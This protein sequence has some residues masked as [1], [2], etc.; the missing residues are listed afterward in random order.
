VL[1]S[2]NLNDNG[3]L[4]VSNLVRIWVVL[5]LIMK[6][7]FFYSS[8]VGKQKL[9]TSL[10]FSISTYVSRCRWIGGYLDVVCTLSETMCTALVLF[11]VVA[12]LPTCKLST[13]IEDRV[14]SYLH[15]KG[16]ISA[17][18]VIIR[19]L[20][21]TEKETEVKPGTRLRALFQHTDLFPLFTQTWFILELFCNNCSFSPCENI[22][23][24][25]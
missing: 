12:G 15:K 18:E 21:F 4:R 23:I 19:I 13:H 8:L 10:S 6:T 1:V 3:N 7:S 24:I 14:N 20:S 22:I 2:D 16:I 11:V 17:G 25:V 9:L 5:L